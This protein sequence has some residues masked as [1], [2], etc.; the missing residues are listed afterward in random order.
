MQGTATGAGC[1]KPT[2][3]ASLGPKDNDS[4]PTLGKTHMD[5][6]VLASRAA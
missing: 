6:L 3:P 4:F 1:M 5:L 2:A